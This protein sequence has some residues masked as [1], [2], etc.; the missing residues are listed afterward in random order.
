MAC[1]P[2]IPIRS[3][4]V[5]SPLVPAHRCRI[6]GRYG[7]TSA[8]DNRMVCRRSVCR[9]I[10]M[11]E[12]RRMS[13]RCGPAPAWQASATI[14]RDDALPC[15]SGLISRRFSVGQ[16]RQ[17]AIF[18]A[19]ATA[20]RISALSIPAL[21][22]D[23]TLVSSIHISDMAADNSGGIRRRNADAGLAVDVYERRTGA[24]L[25]SNHRFSRSR[26][27]KERNAEGLGPQ[28]RGEHKSPAKRCQQRLLVVVG[29]RPRRSVTFG[30]LLRWSSASSSPVPAIMT[31]RPLSRA[32]AM[33]KGSPL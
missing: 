20:P 32:A 3:S 31:G 19:V 15:P 18:S 6:G 23:D 5:P 21:S 28:M 22:V 14:C 8:G 7:C 27:L 26:G 4:V 33:R 17:R 9:A 11:P 16:R 10:S 24:D 1:G 13:A 29:I 2:A 25:A 30:G 12:A